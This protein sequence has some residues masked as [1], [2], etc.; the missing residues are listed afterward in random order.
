MGVL[1]F[2]PRLEESKAMQK[3][4]NVENT[5]TAEAKR[6]KDS[7]IT[8]LT[9]DN[10]LKLLPFPQIRQKC[11]GLQC[12]ILSPRHFNCTFGVGSS[13]ADFQ[14]VN[15]QNQIPKLRNLVPPPTHCVLP[16]TLG[17]LS[18]YAIRCRGKMDDMFY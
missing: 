5:C 14:F 8:S 9:R 11:F 2:F 17:P 1:F 7:K 12:W 16:L 3:H 18:R 15:K 10:E 4:L 13:R 6:E